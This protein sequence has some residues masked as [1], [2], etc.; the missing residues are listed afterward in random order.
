MFFPT[1][2]RWRVKEVVANIT[3][4]TPIRNTHEL[5]QK[6]SDDLTLLSPL[7]EDAGN[8]SSVVP[9]GSATASILSTLSKFTV[10]SVPQ[11]IV[12]CGAVVHTGTHHNLWLPCQ[13]D[14]EDIPDK[15]DRFLRLDV[16]PQAPP[17]PAAGK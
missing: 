5:W 1:T 6:I 14:D 4:L 9:G 8:L 7:I 12:L 11:T 3:F 2:G 15:E 16:D 13:A 17:E 10:A